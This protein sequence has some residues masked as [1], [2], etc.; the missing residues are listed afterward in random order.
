MASARPPKDITPARFFEEWLPAEVARAGVKP[1]ADT[2]VRVE[3]SG[4]GGGS[5]DLNV[6]PSGMKVTAAADTPADVA[7]RQTVQDWRAVAVGE[8]GAVNLAPP[9]ASPT[10]VLFL[11]RQAQQI[12]Q[13][14]KGIVR[15]EVTGYNGRTWRTDVKIG[16]STAW[17]VSGEPDATITVD[18]DTYGQMLARQLAPPQAFFSGKIRLTGDANLAMALGMG[19]MGRM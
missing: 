2:T 5:W 9:Q 17:K 4:E 3:L 13:T 1:A 10:D 14:V 7:I 15:F 12:L 8:E 16:R 6:G 18:A 19:M 11:D